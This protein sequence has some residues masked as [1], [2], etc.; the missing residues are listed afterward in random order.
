MGAGTAGSQSGKAPGGLEGAPD[1][2]E[3]A[4]AGKDVG[5]DGEK[6]VLD[7]LLGKTYRPKGFVDVKLDTEAGLLPL[8]VFLRALPETRLDEIDA[9][10][11]EGDGPFSKLDVA[12]FNAAVLAE[13]I[14]SF[15]DPN[16]AD[17]KVSPD[18]ESFVGQGLNVEVAISG[19]LRYQPGIMQGLVEE[20]RKLSGYAPERVGTAQRIIQTAVGNSSG[21]GD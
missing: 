3:N 10:N 16:D 8:R 5:D 19:R 20:V 13:A 11:R 9:A 1:E 15:G 18:D 6:K 12:G 17:A 14:E 7:Y 2:L 4:A 21:A